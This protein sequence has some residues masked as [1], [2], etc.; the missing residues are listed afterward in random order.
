MEDIGLLIATGETARIEFK[1]S[2]ADWRKIVETVAAMATIGGGIVLVGVRP[3]GTPE[4]VEVGEGG[5]ERIIQ[6]VLDNTDPRVFVDVERVDHDG[7]CLLKVRVPP[8]DGP[9][10]AF[11]RAFHRPGP[12]TVRMTRD[13]YERRLLDRLRESSGFER[14][15]VEGA[16]EIDEAA[17]GSFVE[18]AAERGVAAGPADAILRRLHLLSGGVLSVGGAL[19]FGREPQGPLP[20]AVIRGRVTRGVAEDNLSAEGTLFDQVE[21]AVAFVARN[22]R[23]RVVIGEEAR[24]LEI[25]ELPPAA[26]REVITNAVTHRDYRSTAPVQL[27]LD[28]DALTVWN[29]GHLPEPITPALL[30]TEHPSVP[31][32]PLIARAMF[33]AGYIEQWGSGTLRVIE[34]MARSGNP[35]PTFSE[36][37]GGIR[38][39]LPLPGAAVDLNPRQAAWFRETERGA[40]FKAADYAAASGVTGRTALNDLNE[41]RDRGLVDRRGAGPGTHWIRL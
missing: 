24:R 17:V 33:L 28:E 7:A 12:A 22:L 38:V 4:G 31:M 36:E 14:R 2:L 32:N 25:P 27:R 39:V 37:R 10:L 40:L 6:R 19:L 35:A 18:L 16:A 23:S 3:D 26:V 11:G 8:G 20:Q 13:E 29:P 1:K 41:L 21:Q 15:A 5:L 9:H 34:E 30:R